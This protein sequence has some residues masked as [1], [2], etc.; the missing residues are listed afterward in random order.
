M[1][2]HVLGFVGIAAVVLFGCWWV[3][4]RALYNEQ[5]GRGEYVAILVVGILAAVLWAGHD[6]NS[7]NQKAAKAL[8]AASG[9]TVSQPPH[10][11][12]AASPVVVVP[13]PHRKALAVHAMRHA[14]AVQKQHRRVA[15]KA[16]RHAPAKKATS[17]PV[18]SQV[19]VRLVVH[20]YYVAPRYTAPA[21]PVYRTVVP[22]ATHVYVAPLQ[23]K[24]P[25]ARYIPP[26]R[27][28]VYHP[29]AP[30][31]QPS[32]PAPAKPPARK[33]VLKVWALGG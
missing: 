4:R 6:P 29:V 18:A 24:A 22:A 25:E 26:V 28:P 23:P 5:S 9:A 1:S 21:T 2:L 7:K 13:V 27:V 15:K 14:K 3:N 11:Q 19:P 10:V 12:P 20:H 32:S 8:P 33:K 17:P 31:A 30:K 16:A